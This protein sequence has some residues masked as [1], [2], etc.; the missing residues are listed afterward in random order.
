MD[1][2]GVA[3][4]DTLP[5]GLKIS[6]PNGL[7]NTCGG[8]A[9]ATAGSGA[10]S[11]V[12]APLAIG[13]SCVVS[14]NVTGTAVGIQDNSVLVSSTNTGPG[15][16][17]HAIVDVTP[18]HVIVTAPSPTTTFGTI[19][20]LTPNYQ[21]LVNGDTPASLTTPAT[22][23]TSA[24]THSPPGTYPVHCSGAVDPNYT[25]TYVPG[26][27]TIVKAPTS[28]IISDFL[29]HHGKDTTAVLGE[30]GLPSNAVGTVLFEDRIG[31]RN[32]QLTGRSGEATTCFADFGS[33]VPFTITGV[34]LDEDG[35]YLNSDST[36]QLHPH[37]R[38][39]PDPT[40]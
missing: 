9:N 32:I 34:F 3:F 4:T 13:A 26:T 19:P 12:G 29:T 15:N 35:N 40:I 7:S 2:T 14:V 38:N 28:F 1:L 37:G 10:V 36:N 30:S 33:N 11:L 25:F 6:T 5:S 22:C 39:A 23:V 16:T 27:L 31:T 24:T 17:A 20:T 18:A 8:T 21:G